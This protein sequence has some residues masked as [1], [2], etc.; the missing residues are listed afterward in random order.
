MLFELVRRA[1]DM[2][3]SDLHLAEK[4]IPVVRVGG[5][6]QPLGQ[7]C[8]PKGALQKELQQLLP[9]WALQELEKNGEVDTAF[10][11][12][13][14]ERCRLNAY[15][16][17]GVLAASIRLLR[18]VVPDCEELGL[19]LAVQGLANLQ[20]GLVLVTGATGSGKST[21][22]AALVQRINEKR[23]VHVLTLEDP[24]EYVYTP[25][26]ALISQREIGRDTQSFAS[27]LRSALRQDP[28]V[29]LVGELRDAETMAIALTAAETG[30][31]VLATLHTQEA[32]GAVGRILDVL[33]DKRQVSVQL[34]EC[35]QA[36]VCQR[37]LPRV[38]GGGRVAAFEVLIAT[39]A[40]RNLIREGRTHQL[41]SYIQTGARFGMQTMAAA[42][43][44]LRKRKVVRQE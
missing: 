3:A 16:Q 19:P 18:S 24:I 27:G 42:I 25:K 20:Q 36:V 4:A 29:I 11:E 21:T 6:L 44:E 34:A 28:D 1:R 10:G 33:P 35:L 17:S 26:L 14:G 40:L 2:D 8:L 12:A 41:E 30:H 9:A 31:L 23:A 39:P 43:E 37:L 38:D 5:S 22:L 7:H 13:A 15:R 32:A